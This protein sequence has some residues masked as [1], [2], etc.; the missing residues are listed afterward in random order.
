MKYLIILFL[1]LATTLSAK[2]SAIAI[3]YGYPITQNEVDNMA[4]RVTRGSLNSMPADR[5]KK[6]KNEVFNQ[7]V[8]SIF[9]AHLA[10]KEKIQK[11][12]EYKR[13]YKEQA[14]KLEL[15]LLV[16]QY[17]KKH[18]KN[19][20][21][22]NKDIKAYY[23]K[24]KSKFV[25]P[26]TA[27]VRHILVKDRATAK[28]VIRNLKGSKNMKKAFLADVKKYSIDPRTKK[29]GGL[30]GTFPKGSIFPALDK[31]IFSMKPG[32]IST[33]PVFTKLGYHIV[34]LEKFT[35]KKTISLKEAKKKGLDKL[36]K[37]EK[38]ASNMRKVVNKDVHKNK[39]KIKII[40]K[41]Y[42]LQ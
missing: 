12:S 25:T 24:N 4:M 5:Q 27:T 34:Y 35:P 11:S 37:R 18:Y 21:V 36:V 40:D 28:R 39:S 29:R 3:V 23:N 14:K 26:E 20:K 6:I 1:F 31:A 7:I 10:K 17:V 8:R 2:S 22:S 32:H 16:S 19:T 33:E 30:L 9:V 15:S 42:N 38:F 13:V 41:K